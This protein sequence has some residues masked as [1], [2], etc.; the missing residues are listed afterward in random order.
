[1][2]CIKSC[3]SLDSE[4]QFHDVLFYGALIC[5]KILIWELLLEHMSTIFHAVLRTLKHQVMMFPVP[6]L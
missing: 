3:R 4:G 5:F 1:M 2:L 6:A